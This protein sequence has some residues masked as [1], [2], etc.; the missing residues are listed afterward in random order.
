MID[1][2]KMIWGRP[3]ARTTK[4]REKLGCGGY[5]EGWGMPR[6]GGPLALIIAAVAFYAF[7]R[8]NGGAD[9]STP[10][11]TLDRRYADGESLR[12]SMTR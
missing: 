8:R 12:T 1:G 6:S 4:S 9:A 5:G 3:M 2:A 10:R 11:A 7:N